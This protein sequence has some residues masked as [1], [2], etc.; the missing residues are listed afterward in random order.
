MNVVERAIGVEDQTFYRHWRLS[1]EKMQR[2][3]TFEVLHH[4]L[5]SDAIHEFARTLVGKFGKL[6]DVLSWEQACELIPRLT[7]SPLALPWNS[8]VLI[9][10]FAL[11]QRRLPAFGGG[12]VSRLCF[13]PD[14][15]T[16]ICACLF[17]L[18]PERRARFEV[19][20]QEFGG[21]E[22]RF[23]MARWRHHQ[24]NTLARRGSY[25]AEGH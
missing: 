9:C 14:L 1:C 10:R 19:V 13:D 11:G 7:A 16:C 15:V 3:V 21:R 23:P 24:D 4:Q 22:C 2:C 5:F 17:N 8:R 25:D 20:H 18:F 12:I 6:L